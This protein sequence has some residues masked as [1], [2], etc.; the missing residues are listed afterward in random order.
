MKVCKTCTK[1]KDES[2]YYK[3]RSGNP[4]AVCKDCHAIRC[5]KVIPDSMKVMYNG[6]LATERQIERYKSLKGRPPS[7]LRHG[8]AKTH[9]WGKYLAIKNRCEYE[10]NNRYHLYGGRGIQCEW[11]QFEDFRDDMYESYLAHVEI[12]GKKDTTI[13]RIDTD[14]NYSKENCR[15]ATRTEQANNKSTNVLYTLDGETHSL[16]DWCRIRGK[17]YKRVWSRINH[18]GFSLEEALNKPKQYESA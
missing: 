8:L 12:H 17:N 16:A 11:S 5:S 13:E 10:K 6:S 1:G 9:F 15:W 3:Y 18:N 14:G 4:F 2:E 7:N